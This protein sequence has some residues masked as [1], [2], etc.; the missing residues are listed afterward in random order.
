[1]RAVQVTENVWWV[2]AID[3][4][5]R[6]FHGFETPDGTTYNAYLVMGES[7][8][9]LIDTVKKPFVPELLARIETVTPLS[10]ITHIVVNHVEPDHNGGLPEVMAA[11][12]QA[13]VVASVV[14]AKSVAEYHNGLEV[15]AVKADDVIDLGGRTITFM[16][17]SMVH[18]PDSMF[19]Y[20]PEE[21]VLMPNDAFGQHVASEE[22]FA[23]ELGVDEAMRQLAV[24]YANILMPL[25]GVVGK[26]I[27]KVVENGWALDVVAPSHGVMW[28]P[29]EFAGVLDAYGRWNTGV[30]A[31]KVVVAYSTMWGSTAD[32]ATAIGDGLAAGGM[33]VEVHD[34]A[35]SPFAH[36]THDLLE[37]KALVLGSPTLH[38]GMLYRVAGYLQYLL[39]LKPAGRVAGIFGSYGWSKGAEKQLRLRLEEAGLEVIA[40]DFLVKFRPTAEDLDAAAAW[41]RDFAAAV[42]SRG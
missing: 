39:G 36:I 7:G 30:L 41:G 14:G 12:P 15:G 20:C 13:Q 3:W 4:N 28:R 29:A 11:M 42:K 5:L 23:D 17:A 26:A 33:H 35:V 6:D 10:S 31:D 37:A 9:A 38:H 1:M 21:R 25:G 34:L 19:T 22:R 27:D 8:I 16:P 32:L 40:D 2:G 18:W 24:Y